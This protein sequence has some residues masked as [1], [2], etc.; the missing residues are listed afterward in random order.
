MEINPMVLRFEVNQAQAFRQGVDVPKSTVHLEIDPSKLSQEERN[1]IADRLHGIDVVPLR[2][3][4]GGEI[5][6]FSSFRGSINRIVADLP[7]YEALMESIR[8][9]DKAVKELLERAKKQKPEQ[10]LELKPE[11][12]EQTEQPEQPEQPE[13]LPELKPEEKPEQKSQRKPKHKAG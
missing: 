13:Q 11:Q 3:I 12:T 2:V 7:T 8:R 10:K 6:Q 5:D 9:N 4:E 1:L